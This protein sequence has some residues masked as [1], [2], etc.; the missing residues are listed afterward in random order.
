[1][2]GLRSTQEC[3]MVL[4]LSGCGVWWYRHL[5]QRWADH[6]DL[7]VRL[8]QKS[9]RPCLKNIKFCIVFSVRLEGTQVIVLIHFVA[10]TN[11]SSTG[12]FFP[13]VLEAGKSK[14]RALALVSTSGLQLFLPAVG[15]RA[16][17][18]K[19]YILKYQRSKGQLIREALILLGGQNPPHLTT[20]Q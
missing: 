1:M 16:R 14:V 7:E 13:K 8:L 19:H 15:G 10:K 17:G 9:S 20:S 5:M 3:Q 4:G 12:H 6:S 18:T 11:P 2:P